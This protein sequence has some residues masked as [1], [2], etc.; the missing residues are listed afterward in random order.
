MFNAS[1]ALLY[2]KGIEA[3]THKGVMGLLGEKFVK[4]KELDKWFSKAIGNAFELRQA[5]DYEIEVDIGKEKTQQ[6]IN[7]AEKFIK[8]TKEFLGQP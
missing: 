5:G 3:K 8:E 2:S 1:R 7:D 4:T 6:I